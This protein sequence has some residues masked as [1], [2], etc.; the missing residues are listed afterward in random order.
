MISLNTN[1][2]YITDLPFED[3][4]IQM[5]D[6]LVHHLTDCLNGGFEKVGVYYNTDDNVNHTL[7]AFNYPMTSV[8]AKLVIK[9]S[10]DTGRL[11][12]NS[13]LSVDTSIFGDFFLG[14]PKNDA[15]KLFSKLE[16]PNHDTALSVYL[17]QDISFIC[18]GTAF[19][20]NKF[21]MS[22]SNINQIIE[23]LLSDSEAGLLKKIESII[24]QKRHLSH[25]EIFETK[26]NSHNIT[27]GE[28]LDY[29]ETNDPVLRSELFELHRLCKDYEKEKEQ[30]LLKP[31]VKTICDRF[32]TCGK[33]YQGIGKDLW[34]NRRLQIIAQHIISE[35][36][37]LTE[38][39]NFDQVI[40]D[41]L[42]L[43]IEEII[44]ANPHLDTRFD[45]AEE[46]L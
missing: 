42:K 16:C 10:S 4:V 33:L 21:K 20:V 2:K 43:K 37:Q 8:D 17:N 13:H 14:I 22:L 32:N 7:T 11:F 19:L 30:L 45:C 38:D 3:Y 44:K 18:L 12:I 26:I 36:L 6:H 23:E 15:Y 25:E 24:V 35:N 27:L 1:L 41:K 28:V 9:F 46:S 29:L 40:F 39:M 5:R 34:L 31:W